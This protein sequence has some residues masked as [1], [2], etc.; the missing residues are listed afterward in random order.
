MQTER[1][2]QYLSVALA[3]V[4]VISFTHAWVLSY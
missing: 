3:M 4:V 1:V 2:Y